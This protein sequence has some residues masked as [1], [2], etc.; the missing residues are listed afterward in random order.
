MRFRTN[1]NKEGTL[2]ETLDVNEAMNE[3]PKK[4]FSFTFGI[5]YSINGRHED[6]F[7]LAIGT[8]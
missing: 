6:I 1:K 2:V 4:G 5:G 8:S 7:A 3:N